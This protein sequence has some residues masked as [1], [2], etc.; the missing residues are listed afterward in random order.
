MERIPMRKPLDFVTAD[1]KVYIQ[2]PTARFA[3]ASPICLT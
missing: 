2:Q 1:V 3:L